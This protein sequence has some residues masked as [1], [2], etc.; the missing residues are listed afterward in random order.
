M[1]KGKELCSALFVAPTRKTSGCK[2]RDL[3][4]VAGTG[5]ELSHESTG[6]SSAA[7]QSGAKCGALGVR[8]TPLDPGL[9]DVAEVWLTLPEAIKTGILAMIRAT[10]AQAE[11]NK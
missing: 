6:N 1:L 4:K 9:A 2:S 3:D 11:P 5:L 8:E 10:G 7:T